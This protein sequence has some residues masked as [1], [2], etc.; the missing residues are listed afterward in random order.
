MSEEEFNPEGV[1]GR[2]VIEP[3][4]GSR[5]EYKL[6]ISGLVIPFSVADAVGEQLSEEWSLDL[7]RDKAG[8]YLSIINKSE[9]DDLDSLKAAI[10]SA[11]GKDYEIE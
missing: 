4:P 11:I 5:G 2:A 3:V 9:R 10:K 6:R 7:C 8:D 1:R